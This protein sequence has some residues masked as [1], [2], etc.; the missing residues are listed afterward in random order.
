MHYLKVFDTQAEYN[1]F[2]ANELTDTND[3]RPNISIVLENINVPVEYNDEI[4]DAI[5]KIKYI[6]GTEERVVLE[7]GITPT[8]HR[9]E[10][11]TAITEVW[12]NCNVREI[13]GELF[14]E[15]S[16]LSSVT[17]SEGLEKLRGDAFED[18]GTLDTLVIPS[19]VI[20]GSGGISSFSKIHNL[21]IN[22]NGVASQSN[23]F[24]GKSNADNIIFGE[25]VTTVG[26]VYQGSVA[27]S[28]TFPSTIERIN[29]DAFSTSHIQ[30]IN[31]P[32]KV[33]DIGRGAL[34]GAM[35]QGGNIGGLRYL[36]RIAV[37]FGGGTASITS[38]D[39]I[40]AGT[41]AIGGGCFE[42]QDDFTSI[43]IPSSVKLIGEYAFYYESSLTSI[44]LNEGLEIIGPYAFNRCS[45]ITTPIIIPNSV[46]SIG[47]NAF[48]RCTKTPSITVGSGVTAIPEKCFQQCSGATAISLSNSV[49]K[50]GS[51][52]FSRCNGLTSYTLPN[53][54][55]EICEAAFDL[56]SNLQRLNLPNNLKKVGDNPVTGC[57]NLLHI[58]FPSVEMMC[59]IE[60]PTSVFYTW[61][62]GVGSDY[63]IDLYVNGTRITN[64]VIP[65]T[66][67]EIK[68]YAFNFFSSLT[69]VSVADSVVNIENDAFGSN[70]YITAVTIGTG[71]TKI[72]NYC[73][74]GDGLQ[75]FTIRATT[76]PEIMQG[77]ISLPSGAIIY[78]PSASVNAYKSATNWSQFASRIQAIP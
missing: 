58:D 32:D 55:E 50:I 72:G 26:T 29:E 6:D 20:S 19:S 77:S 46:K 61:G 34:V 35:W 69:S 60:Y 11:N 38:P 67:T 73:F 71:I 66:I 36:N 53:S 68:P 56:C 28:V 41:I 1:D 43:I 27:S 45:G 75:S 63:G 33:I 76:P 51:Y 5:M 62:E 52:A 47:N 48:L 25:G 3:Y 40:S 17:L 14:L 64:L 30:E 8:D 78:V 24:L 70:E 31:A 42:D 2:V 59:S 9:Y 39:I 22:S 44:T 7:S 37:D 16:N 12:F 65:N 23:G 54:V 57:T 21:I 49:K 13:T 15:C 4:A 10:E 74:N 18:I